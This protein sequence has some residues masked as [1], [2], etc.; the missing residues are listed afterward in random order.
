MNPLT[1]SAFQR[2]RDFRYQPKNLEEPGGRGEG[3]RGGQWDLT[4]TIQDSGEKEFL[5][6]L[7]TNI[8]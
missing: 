4:G 3:V 7:K 1:S 6:T 5:H 8:T 2:L